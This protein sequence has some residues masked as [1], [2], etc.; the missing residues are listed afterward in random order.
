MTMLKRLALTLVLAC[1][2]VTFSGCGVR[3]DLERPP[4][5]WGPDE[6]SESERAHET[7]AETAD[8][9]AR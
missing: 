4:P 7:G 9:G 6:R 5:V 3:G 8:E 1:S 2:A